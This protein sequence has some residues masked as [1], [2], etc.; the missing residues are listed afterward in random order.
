MKAVAI[1]LSAACTERGHCQ[2]LL[3]VLLVLPPVLLVK[4]QLP[5]TTYVD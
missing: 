5:L 1:I 4:S 3:S 2:G